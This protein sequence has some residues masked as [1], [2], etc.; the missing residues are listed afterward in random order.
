MGL[1][2][3]IPVRLGAVTS[4]TRLVL[5]WAVAVAVGLLVAVAIGGLLGPVVGAFIAVGL[6]TL[7]LRMLEQHR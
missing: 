2:A 6:K 7:A 3:M 5:A 4:T 1:P